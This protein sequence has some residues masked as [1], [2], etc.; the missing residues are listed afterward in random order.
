MAV[1]GWDGLVGVLVLFM[2]LI[3]IGWIL[4]IVAIVYIMSKKSFL[5][6]L[7]LF[8]VPIGLL[9]INPSP[10]TLEGTRPI[11]VQIGGWLQVATMIYA[12]YLFLS[13][14]KKGRNSNSITNN[15]A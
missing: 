9:T 15:T 11:T 4:Y 10:P 2:L 1:S 5:I 8:I 6:G 7:T 14:S 13:G 12:L 3:I